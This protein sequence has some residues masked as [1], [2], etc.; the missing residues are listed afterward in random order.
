MNTHL[1]GEQFCSVGEGSIQSHSGLGRIVQ[2]HGFPTLSYPAFKEHE[3]DLAL[4]SYLISHLLKLFSCSED[5][6]TWH[7]CFILF[8]WSSLSD[9]FCSDSPRVS[10]KQLI[11]FFNVY[12]FLRERERDRDRAWVGKGQR[13]REIQNLK[14]ALSCQHRAQCGTWTHE[15]WDDDVS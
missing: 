5:N 12:L 6:I 4:N 2:A 13:E 10:P 3:W 7:S 8:H 9:L 14:Q 15:L 1:S 11:I